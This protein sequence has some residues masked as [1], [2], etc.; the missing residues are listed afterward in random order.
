MNSFVWT[1]VVA[2]LLICT[3]CADPT[4]STALGT[5]ERGRID[6]TADSNKPIVR[7]LVTEGQSVAA[8]DTLVMLDTA[9]PQVTL[10]Q[11]EAQEAA[12]WLALAEAEKG[13]RQQQIEQARSRLQAAKSIMDTTRYELDNALALVDRQLVA[14]NTVDLTAGRH[15]E[16]VAKWQEA[17]SALDELLEGSRSEAIDQAR[18]KHAAA[19]A[20]VENLKIT[21]SGAKVV[22]PVAGTIEFIPFEIGERPPL[23]AT[24]VTTLAKG[25]TYARIYVSA[26]IRGALVSGQE[27]LVRMDGRAEA[28]KGNLRWVSSQAAFTPYFALNQHDR[29]QL[30]YVAEVDICCADEPHT[31]LVGVPVE[32][33]F[34]GLPTE[35]EVNER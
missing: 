29:S 27:A 28:I 17:R 22:A 30:S 19:L 2:L 32:V 33:T 6:L 14:A 20:E 23:G 16:A 15:D 9:R 4:T 13:P 18:A 7:I 8:G 21:L 11:A 26:S 24:V 5:L 25:P 35:R 10:T 3:G 1:T 31:L 34:V 12:A